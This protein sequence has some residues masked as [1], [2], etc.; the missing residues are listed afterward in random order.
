MTALFLDNN[1]LIGYIFET[2]NWS[3]KSV[4][5]M[6][7]TSRKFSSNTVKTECSDIYNKNIGIIR[8]E[9]QRTIA[10]MKKSKSFELSKLLSF[11]DDFYSKDV[12]VELFNS[13]PNLKKD[14]KVIVNRLRNLLR[15]AE[16]RCLVNLLNLE[17]LIFFCTR[18]NSYN[19]IYELFETDGLVEIEPIDVEIILDAHHVGLKVKDLFLITG[20]Y[21]HI[22]N[23]KN[24]IKDN[25]SLKDV[26]GLGEFNIKQYTS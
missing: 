2:D 10:E 26:I 6:G 4:E 12:I 8:K 13:N 5:V 23:R 11:T 16:S 19:E 20:D 15:D 21:I 14:I 25:T 7:C 24:L 1:V 18:N 17:T 22:V 9:F 3:S